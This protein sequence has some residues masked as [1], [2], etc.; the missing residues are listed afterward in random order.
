MGYATVINVPRVNT[1]AHAKR[2]CDSTKPIRGRA[3]E[4]KPLGERRDAD[5]YSIR[6]QTYR[7]SPAEGEPVEL[8][9]Y[10]TPVVTFKQDGEVDIFTDGYN[11]MSTHQFISRTLGVSAHASRGVSVVCLGGSRDNQ[12]NN[13]NQN[14]YAMRGS[15]RLTIKLDERGNWQYVRGAAP[16]FSWKLNRAALTIVR[17]RFKEFTK[18]FKNMVNLR[19]ENLFTQRYNPYNYNPYNPSFMAVTVTK[20]EL[21]DMFSDQP[22][23][24][25]YAR[26]DLDMR[27]FMGSLG[28][29]TT[30]GS[31]SSTARLL[32]LMRS[33]QLE[34]DKHKNFYRAALAV[35][36][37]AK[38]VRVVGRVEGT[39]VVG[40]ADLA[41]HL[42]ELIA[43]THA[44]EILVRTELPM[45]E[46]STSKYDKWV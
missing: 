35:L 36:M 20:Q 30:K 10:N 14:S 24:G 33:D 8:V 26:S 18:Y 21:D 5:T 34:D 27:E 46:V 16:Q 40:A 17:S 44:E 31:Y 11:S 2:I 9:L 1:Y 32:G 15:D 43:Q 28:E 12:S 37:D 38:S 4:L 13:K 19:T 3:V 39:Q 41:A 29:I 42:S 22:Q 25:V 7:G 23:D 6:V 45:G